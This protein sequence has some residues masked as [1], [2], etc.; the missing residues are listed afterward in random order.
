[1]GDNSG[2]GV[3]FSRDPGTG[4]SKLYGEYLINAQGEDVV[5]GIRTPSPIS[6]MELVLPEAYAK[7]IDNVQ[8]LE[9]HFHEMQ[10]VEFTVE[11]GRLWMLQCRT[12]KRSGKA[13]FRIA[14]DM[15]NEG[16]ASKE[17]AILGIDS[18][19]VQQML[20]KEFAADV[21]KSDQYKKNVVAV[22]LPGGP[23][24]AVGKIV[25][26]T[27]EAEAMKAMGEKVILVAQNTSPEGE[28]CLTCHEFVVHLI[29]TP[30][31]MHR[32]DVG[33]MWASQGILTQRGGMTSHAAVGE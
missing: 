33:G 18:H 28:F 31:L 15:V 22:G 25:L 9:K 1:M 16:L 2:T 6:Q 32:T 21:L 17:E 19:H 3:A 13:A 7:F 20:H 26:S 29:Y 12:G 4:E 5:A 8:K 24:A 14:V 30:S 10:D 11:N 27:E 23:G